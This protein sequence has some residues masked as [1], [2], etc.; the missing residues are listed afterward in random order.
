[1]SDIEVVHHVQKIIAGVEE[2]VTEIRPVLSTQRIVINADQSIAIVNAG[3]VGPRGLPG[4][5]G[6]GAVSYTHIQNT[7]SLVWTIQHNL[8]YYP[9]GI[10]IQDSANN[11]VEAL[12]AHVNANVLTITFYEPT[13]GRAYV[14]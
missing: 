10:Y 14:S 6:A 2:T 7:P 4:L 9:G 3:P 11:D 8:T 1:M 5:S 13:S 12:V